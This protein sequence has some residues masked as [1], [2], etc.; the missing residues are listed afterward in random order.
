MSEATNQVYSAGSVRQDHNKSVLHQRQHSD[1]LTK[2]SLEM[3]SRIGTM[4]I[5]NPY[6]F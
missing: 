2:E 6:K 1:P 3:I 4:Y 5:L